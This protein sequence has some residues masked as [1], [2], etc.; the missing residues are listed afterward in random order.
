MPNPTVA[1]D[2]FPRTAVVR[3]RFPRATELDIEA[4]VEAG[5]AKI[6][7]KSGERIAITA[8]SRG[9]VNV[10]RTV[11]AVVAALKKR[12]VLP[13]ILPAMGS[14]GGATPEGQTEV[15]AT[16]GITPESA[17]CP[18]VADMDVTQIGESIDGVAAYCSTPALRCDGIVVVNRVKPHTDFGGPYGSGLLKMMAIGLGKQIGASAIHHASARLGLA[19]SILNVG[20]EVLAKAPIRCGVALVENAVHQTSHI[21]VIARNQIE[22]REQAL[23]EQAERS[24]GRLPIDNIDLLIVDQIGKDVSGCG[25]DPN[26]IGRS[27]FGY[28]AALFETPTTRPIVRRIFVRDLTPD[29]HGNASGLGMADFTTRRLVDQINWEV[30]LMNAL[31]SL[32][33][34]AAKIPICL[35][36]DREII[37]IALATLA[38]PDPSRARVVRIRD[39]LSVEILELSEACLEDSTVRALEPARPLGGMQFDPQ[40]N[41]NVLF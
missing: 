29:T 35:E 8:G 38:L 13:F 39:T 33:V 7:F 9:I 19:K 34:T 14:H 28:S 36:T 27:I 11:I 5:L 20:K 26:V 25:M 15:I 16:W 17:G 2:Q 18:I 3:Q 40:G 24:M 1:L 23:Y 22:E 4:I 41:L 31:T 10:A 30:T 6:P 37:G 32:A 21:E 12:G